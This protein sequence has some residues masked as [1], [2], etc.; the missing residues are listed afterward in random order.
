MAFQVYETL[1]T[2]ASYSH[3]MLYLLLTSDQ[4]FSKADTEMELGTQEV[5]QGIK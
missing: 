3:S 1:M 2:I 5:Y 4:F